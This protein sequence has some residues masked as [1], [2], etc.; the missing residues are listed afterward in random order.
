LF[1]DDYNPA[2]TWD[3][4]PEFSS[5]GYFIDCVLNN[6]DYDAFLLE[7]IIV[8]NPFSVLD[9]EPEWLLV[10]QKWLHSEISP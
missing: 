3:K 5:D 1:N 10:L 8:H 9:D 7:E 6:G 2:E 4:V